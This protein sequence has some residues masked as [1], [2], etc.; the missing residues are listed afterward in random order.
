MIRPVA[1]LALLLVAVTM[2]GCAPTPS[3]DRNPIATIQVLD[4]TYRVELATPELVAHAT[5]LLA[6]ES[7]AAI[8]NGLVVR[9]DPGPNA[10]WS[11]HIDPDTFEFASATTEVCDGLPSFVERGEITSPYFCP[12]SATVIAVE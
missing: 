9:G 7:V 11:W 8:P 6:G 4:E 3:E 2:P 5:A 12:W 1:A 10:P